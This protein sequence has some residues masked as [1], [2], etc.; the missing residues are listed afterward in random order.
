M[1]V[2]GEFLFQSWT[3]V[4]SAIPLKWVTEVT[5]DRGPVRVLFL[6]RK[7]NAGLPQSRHSSFCR[8][9]KQK[10]TPEPGIEPGSP[11]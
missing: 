10:R 7:K 1:C 11:A 6:I 5:A 4:V 9:E 8:D 3:E 2:F